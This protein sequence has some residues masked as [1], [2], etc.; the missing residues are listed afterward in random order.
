MCFNLKITWK[1]RTR[2]MINNHTR[3]SLRARIYSWLLI[4]ASQTTRLNW[5]YVGSSSENKTKHLV[6][7]IVSGIPCESSRRDCCWSTKLFVR[8]DQLTPYRSGNLVTSNV[9]L[10]KNICFKNSVG[11]GK[12]PLNGKGRDQSPERSIH[13]IG[14][15]FRAFSFSMVFGWSFLDNTF[16]F[17]FLS[18]FYDF[19]AS[20]RDPFHSMERL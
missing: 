16:L 11:I 18:K 17:G 1:F 13:F 8:T 19:L 6:T 20:Y 7:P 15:N 2:P 4:L 10:S 3:Y 12:V 5:Q 14:S 9:E